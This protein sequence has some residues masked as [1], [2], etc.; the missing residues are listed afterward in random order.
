MKLGLFLGKKETIDK[1][2]KKSEYK[3]D[4]REKNKDDKDKTKVKKDK[5]RL[6]DKI[7]D[8]KVKD[9]DKDKS[10]DDKTKT[11]KSKSDRLIEEKHKVKSKSSE[12]KTKTKLPES[13][14]K[15]PEDNSENKFSEEKKKEVKPTEDNIEQK[16]IKDDKVDAPIAPGNNVS[17]DI[18]FDDLDDLDRALEMALEKKLEEKKIELNNSDPESEKTNA[19]L[20]SS[21]QENSI[22]PTDELEEG[23]MKAMSEADEENA[24]TGVK[25]MADLAINKLEF[26]DL[27]TDNLSRLQIVFVELQTR[28]TD[29]T[30]GGLSTEYFLQQLRIAEALLTDYELSAVPDGWAC[31]WDRCFIAY[32]NYT[33]TLTLNES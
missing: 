3:K 1:I 11:D 28:L 16:I 6:E 13:D 30:A 7:K 29:W 4:Y 26:L 24:K 9:Y 5:D 31:Q 21:V 15:A 8:K 17:V 23:E 22:K 2:K 14:D 27:G 25:E 10:I 32:V 20:P 33:M 18:D 19:E 12:N